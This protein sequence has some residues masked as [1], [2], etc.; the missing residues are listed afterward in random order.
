MIALL[1]AFSALAPIVKD[2]VVAIVEVIRDSP[3]PEESAKRALD[4]ARRLR[5]FEKRMRR[6]GT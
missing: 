6:R 5:E 3:N 4:E 2:L 1:K